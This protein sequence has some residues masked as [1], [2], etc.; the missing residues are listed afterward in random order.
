MDS[1]S[2]F[3][4]T[5]SGFEASVGLGPI[6]RRRGGIVRA[7]V[8]LGKPI[9]L[10]RRLKEPPLTAEIKAPTLFGGWRGIAEL[11]FR[12]L[13]L[14]RGVTSE[15]DFVSL[16]NAAAPAARKIRP[17]GDRGAARQAQYC[18]GHDKRV[19]EHS[20]AGLSTAN[21]ILLAPTPVRWHHFA[22]RRDVSE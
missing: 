21:S 4:Q 19:E 14:Q 9:G 10:F 5:V 13:P 6:D 18:G 17:G 7:V 20:A 12:I 11:N 8:G 3:R 15:P 1:K 22:A 16:V 2:Q